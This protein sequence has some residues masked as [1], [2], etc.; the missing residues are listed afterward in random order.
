MID[1]PSEEYPH[2]SYRVS[3]A[4]ALTRQSGVTAISAWLDRGSPLSLDLLEL[5]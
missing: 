5:E 1:A 2:Q 3:K 4:T